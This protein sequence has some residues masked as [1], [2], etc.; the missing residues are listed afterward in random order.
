MSFVTIGTVKAMFFFGA[1]FNLCPCFPHLLSDVCAVRCKWSAR[2][3]LNICELSDNRFGG[4]AVLSYFP[5]RD[6]IYLCTVKLHAILKVNYVLEKQEY[7]VTE[8]AICILLLRLLVS[9]YIRQWTEDI[10]M[11]ATEFW[12]EDG[13]SYFWVSFES[14]TAPE[15]IWNFKVIFSC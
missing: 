11:R 13:G 12:K 6:Y 5:K 7:F 4:K 8:C 15:F 9:H 14:V 3:A 1:Q 2:N 10:K